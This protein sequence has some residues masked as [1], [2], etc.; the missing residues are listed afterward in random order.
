[1]KIY[2]IVCD[3]CL[4]GKGQAIPATHRYH[5]DDDPVEGDAHDICKGCIEVVESAGFH[6]YPIENEN[7]YLFGEE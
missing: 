1:M 5:Q 4:T 7:A 2:V 3:L 6:P